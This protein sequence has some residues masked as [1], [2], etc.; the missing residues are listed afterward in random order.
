[1]VISAHLL[2]FANFTE[3]YG[4]NLELISV[5]TKHVL[6]I[7]FFKYKNNLLFNYPNAENTDAYTKANLELY[8]LIIDGMQKKAIICLSEYLNICL[9]D[10]DKRLNSLKE[11][12]PDNKINNIHQPFIKLKDKRARIHGLPPNGINEFNAFDEFDK[13]L[14]NISICLESLL[15]W[16]EDVLNTDA[17]SCKDREDS[18]RLFPGIIA[19]PR[20]ESKNDDIKKAVGKKIKS[21]EF[22]EVKECEDVHESEAIIFHFDDDTS[23]AVIVGSNAQNVQFQNENITPNEFHTDLMI[24]WANAIKRKS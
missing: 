20:P 10:E 24:F 14:H 7:P 11:L 15:E 16:L 8:R 22:G 9:T 6:G 18:L 21:I 23:M 4:L 19:P 2:L 5:L 3:N 17:K 13:D 1:M 12:L